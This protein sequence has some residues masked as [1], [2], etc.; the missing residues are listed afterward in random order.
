VLFKREVR[1][2]FAAGREDEAVPEEWTE[3]GQE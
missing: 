3:G 2:A 1:A